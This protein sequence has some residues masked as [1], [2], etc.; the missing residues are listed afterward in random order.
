MTFISGT[1]T[2]GVSLGPA[3]GGKKISGG[4][5]KKKKDPAV[6]VKKNSGS[7]RKKIGGAVNRI[8]KKNSVDE[9]AIFGGVLASLK[10]S[11][12]VC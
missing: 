11:V 2:P 10:E 9:R 12:S 4:R 7:G 6:D 5:R 1:E 3:V 8:K